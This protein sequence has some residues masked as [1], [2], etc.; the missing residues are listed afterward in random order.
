M[1]YTDLLNQYAGVSDTK[2]ESATQAAQDKKARLTGD[3]NFYNIAAAQQSPNLVQGLAPEEQDAAQLDYFDFANKYGYERADQLLSGKLSGVRDFTSDSEARRSN[4]DA[5]TDSAV[6]VGQGV[7]N[8]VG[9]TAALAGGMIHPSLGGG[10][11]QGLDWLNQKAESFKSNSLAARQRT[12]AAR[13]QLR[14]NINDAQYQS[15][16]ENGA[17]I[18]ADLA[19]MGRGFIDG[20]AES[21][22]DPQAAGDLLSQGVGSIIPVGTSARLAQAGI[23]ALRGTAVKPGAWAG[24]SVIGASTAGGTYQQ[25]YTEALQRLSDRS[26]LSQ[27]EKESI[28]NKAALTAAAVVAPAAVAAGRL[29]APFEMSPLAKGNVSGLISKMGGEF[30]EEGVQ[31]GSEKF[32]QNIGIKAHVDPTQSISEGVGEQMGEGAIAGLGTAGVIGVPGT[33]TGTVS[34][35]GRSRVKRKREDITKK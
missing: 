34:N 23:N 24:A 35:L 26:D 15:D 25:T 12:V 30:L 28:A 13:K 14:Q 22:S 27:E 33:V 19:R 31:S 11:T 4:L 29:V 6:G 3:P 9:G 20:M 5:V 21:I 32:G 17:G 16:I 18:E 10:I 7:A 2:R 1:D 8:F